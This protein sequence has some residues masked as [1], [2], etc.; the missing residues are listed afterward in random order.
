MKIYKSF[1]IMWILVIIFIPIM[2][3]LLYLHVMKIGN[4]PAPT[5]MVIIIEGILMFCLL[6]FIRLKTAITDHEIKLSFGIGLINKRIKLADVESTRV[7]RNKWYYGLGIKMIP[8]GWLWN[9][10]GLGAVELT[11]KNRDDIIRIGS[12]ESD[13]LKDEIDKR[14]INEKIP[15]H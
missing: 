13:V 11:F 15:L 5:I 8:H 9:A 1:Q 14:L 6:L 3:L 12:P 7:V 4:N 10:H 2:I